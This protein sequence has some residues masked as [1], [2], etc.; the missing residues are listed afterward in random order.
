MLERDFPECKDE[1]C[2]EVFICKEKGKIML[3]SSE[4]N[5][6]VVA[7]KLCEEFNKTCS[8]YVF[9][10][11]L[12]FLYTPVSTDL[13]HWHDLLSLEISDK[14]MQSTIYTLYS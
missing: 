13:F 9:Q 12:V 11:G 14:S 5:K 7:A 4:I 8:R 1:M 10:I 2:N 6:H 3:S